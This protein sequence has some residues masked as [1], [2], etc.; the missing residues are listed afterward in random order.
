MKKKRKKYAGFCNSM[1]AKAIF[2]TKN[3]RKQAT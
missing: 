1:K 2:M 3:E